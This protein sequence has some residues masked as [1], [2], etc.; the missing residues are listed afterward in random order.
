MGTKSPGE[1]RSYRALRIFRKMSERTA[2]LFPVLLC[3]VMLASCSVLH[4][5]PVHQMSYAEAAV[6]S[7]AAAGAESSQPY[8]FQLSRDALL[9]AHSA[10]RL[11]NFDMALKLAIRARRIAEDAETKA[12]SGQI[13]AEKIYSSDSGAAIEVE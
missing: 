11:K 5:R 13:E 7:A 10:Y 9:R 4:S 3:S 6:R 12:L 2:R 8:L 1:F